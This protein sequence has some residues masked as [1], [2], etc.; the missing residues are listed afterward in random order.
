MS[1]LYIDKFNSGDIEIETKDHL[2]DFFV[3]TYVDTRIS[4][5]ISKKL[6]HALN[7][8]VIGF[9]RCH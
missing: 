5:W 8:H 6:G 2:V 1:E 9:G 4:T 7:K 3:N